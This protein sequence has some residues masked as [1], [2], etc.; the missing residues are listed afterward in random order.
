MFWCRS[1]TGLSN[2]PGFLETLEHLLLETDGGKSA[3]RRVSLVDEICIGS[4]GKTIES[5]IVDVTN[6]DTR[7]ADEVQMNTQGGTS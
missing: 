2:C 1:V 7:Y 3:W 6:T 4:R 5:L